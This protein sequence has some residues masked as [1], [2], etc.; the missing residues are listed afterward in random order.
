MGVDI[1]K[2]R[3]AFDA[4]EADDFVSAKEILQQEIHQAKDTFLKDKLGLEKD[5]AEACGKK[6][7]AKKVVKEES[8]E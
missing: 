8:K 5:V 3:S 7:M 1:E 2:V 6:K 4:F